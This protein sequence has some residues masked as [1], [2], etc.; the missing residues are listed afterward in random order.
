MDNKL[1][2][3]R[4]GQPVKPSGIHAQSAGEQRKILIQD[5]KRWR[6]LIKLNEDGQFKFSTMSGEFTIDAILD[7]IDILIEEDEVAAR[8]AKRRARYNKS[9]KIIKDNEE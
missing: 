1:V 3:I 8:Q 7:H 4:T 5:G 9:E 2:D 6:K